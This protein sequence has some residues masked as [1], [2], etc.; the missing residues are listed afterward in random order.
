MGDDAWDARRDARGARRSWRA[1]LA[2]SLAA[3]ALGLSTSFVDQD[4]HGARGAEPRR[5]RR[6]VLRARSTCWAARPAARARARV[7]ALDQGDRAAARRHRPRRALVRRR[8]VACT[9]NQLAENSRDPSRAERMIEQAH[10][11][12]AD[13]CRVY[14]QVSPRPFNLQRELRP[15][16]GVHRDP[17]WGWLIA[18][19]PDEKRRLL[20]DRDVARRRPA[21]TGT[22]VGDGFTIFPVIAPR[23]RAPH[24]RCVPGRSGSSTSTFADVVAAR[25]GHPSDVLA[26][27]VLEHDLAPGMV[28]EALSNNDARQGVGAHRRPHDG[29]RRQ[30]RRRAPADDV[31]RRRLHAAAHRARARPR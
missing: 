31:R 18:Q 6:R 26:D 7:P 21:P 13:G 17:A 29:R 16:A 10:E 11:L 19:P 15:D 3:G 20:A 22:S 14:A 1:V 9:W 5:R 25:G 28:A 8:G 4:R 30:R 23:P 12:H 27:W 24:R 2:E